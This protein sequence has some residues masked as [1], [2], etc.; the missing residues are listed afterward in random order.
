MKWLLLPWLLALVTLSHLSGYDVRSGRGLPWEAALLLTPSGF[1]SYGVRSLSEESRPFD[2]IYDKPALPR[3]TKSVN[4]PFSL[5]YLFIFF[6][7]SLIETVVFAFLYKKIS[8]GNLRIK[9]SA[10]VTSLSNSVTHPLVF[11]G[12]MASTLSYF[13]AVLFAEA[14]AVGAETLLHKKSL[15]SNLS[16]AQVFGVSL[17]ANL[18]SWQLGPMFTKTWLAITGFN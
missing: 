10:L 17:L 3:V 16:W 2:H 6:Q 9:R 11:F 1:V 18:A 4:F 12:F 13:W 8:R 15:R 5:S 14:F 7:S